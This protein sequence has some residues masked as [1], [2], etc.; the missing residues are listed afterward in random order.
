MGTPRSVKDKYGKA[1]PTGKDA[2]YADLCYGFMEY[3]YQLNIPIQEAEKLVSALILN[4]PQGHNCRGRFKSFI[5]L[6]EIHIR[7]PGMETP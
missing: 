3:L 1:H 6:T 2:E 7:K 4:D 5:R